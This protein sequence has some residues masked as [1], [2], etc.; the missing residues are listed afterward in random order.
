MS[1]RV[2]KFLQP[3]AGDQPCGPDLSYDPGFDEMESTLQGKPEVEIGTVKRPAE[4]PDWR[5]LTEQSE[6]LLG[7]TKHLRVALVVGCCWLKKDGLKGLN[8]GLV[9]LRGLLEQSWATLHPLLDPEDSNDPTQRLNIL[10]SLTAPRGSISGWLTFVDYLHETPLAQPKGMP[11]LTYMDILAARKKQEGDGAAATGGPDMAA[12]ASALRA[13][14]GEQAAT[15]HEALQGALD[16]VKGIDQF[17]TATLGASESI[18]FEVLESLLKDLISVLSP[19]LP[20]GA[21]EAGAEAVAAGESG[22][23]PGSPAGGTTITVSGVIRSREDVIRT[24]DGICEYYRQIEPGSP[25]P[26][27]LRR[28]QKLASMNFVQAVQELNLATTDALRPSMG[29][30]LD[31]GEAQQPSAS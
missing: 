6:A 22:A 3:I 18:S 10:R 31:S 14:G 25:V 20:G 17:L 11:P 2:E 5:A 21:T 24:L 15:R 9:L 30:A 8:D 7:R 12:V 13:A 4:P 23:A 19:Y 29:S 28:A 26:F 1:E 27:L 16:A